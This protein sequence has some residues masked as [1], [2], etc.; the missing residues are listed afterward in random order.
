MLSNI[1]YLGTVEKPPADIIQNIRKDIHDFLWNYRKVRV[2]RNN[3]TLPIEMGALARMDIE[4]QIEAIQCSILAKFIKE[5]N[6]DKTWTDLMLWH[7]DQCR[8]AKQGVN[9]FK[10]CIGNTDRAPI[11]PTYKT[12]LSSWSSFTGNETPAPKTLPEIYNEPIF[13]NTKSDGI[14]TLRYF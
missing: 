7:L 10:T 6:Q 3:I 11:L 2:N 13:F 8:K 5:K 4:T 12:F 1:W 14:N 9:I